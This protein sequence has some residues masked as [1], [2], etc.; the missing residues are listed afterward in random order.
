MGKVDFVHQHGAFDLYQAIDAGL[1]RWVNGRGP[2][3]ADVFDM[4]VE[5]DP[6]VVGPLA[7][8]ANARLD[9]TAAAIDGALGVEPSSIDKAAARC[10]VCGKLPR[11]SAA[12]AESYAHVFNVAAA[13]ARA[14]AAELRE[15][16]WQRSGNF[17][18]V[19]RR[20][21][22]LPELRESTGYGVSKGDGGKLEPAWSEQ[23]WRPE[24]AVTLASATDVW[25]AKR[26]AEVI[27]E[28]LAS[29]QA[30]HAF[31]AQLRLTERR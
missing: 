5:F 11:D 3:C 23:S 1:V 17:W 15:E 20:V 24:W 7:A 30:R 27:A 13:V 21:P 14:R 19:L 25:T 31:L 12:H 22:G 8:A 26:R 18:S 28:A 2:E 29:K 16:G 4:E 10:A 9:E 6:D